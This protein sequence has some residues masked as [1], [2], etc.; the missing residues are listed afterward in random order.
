MPRIQVIVDE[1]EREAFR[2]QAEA[3]GRSLSEWLREA[4]RERL[5]RSQPAELRTRED[6]ERFFTGCDER[7][8]GREPDWDQHL[9]VIAQ[10]R[11]S[12]LPR[13]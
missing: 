8:T 6:L 11:G 7:E 9:E 1:P 4:G 2:T 3:E 12:G 10:S 13:P 5:A